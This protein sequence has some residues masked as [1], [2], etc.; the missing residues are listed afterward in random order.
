MLAGTPPFPGQ[1][2]D[3]VLHQHLRAAP[4]VLAEVPA[5]VAAATQRAMS[6]APA[7]RYATAQEFAAALVPPRTVAPS[8]PV[9]RWI[10]VGAV[11]AVAAVPAALVLS[12]RP[13]SPVPAVASVVGVLPLTPTV[14]DTHLARLGRDLV[15]TLSSN[16]DGVSG[17]RTV[18]ALTI[19]ALTPSS[20]S[21]TGDAGMRL[22][23][24]LGASAAVLGSIGREGPFL[25]VDARMVAIESGRVLARATAVAGLDDLGALTD[26]VTWTLLRGIWQTRAPPTPNPTALT[27]RSMPALRAFL[28]GE[29]E[30]LESRWDAASQSYE[31]AMQADSTFWLAYWRYAFARWWYLEAVDDDIIAAIRRHRYAL[32]ERDRLVFDSWVTDTF[33]VAVA[34]STE[35]TRRFPD[36]WPGWMQ[37]ADWLFHV[38][39]VYGHDREESKAALRRTVAL[40]PALIPAWEHL[41]WA[42]MPDDPATA[43]RALEE[44]TRLGFSR[45]SAAEFGYDVGRVY[46]FQLAMRRTGLVDA[47]LRDSIVVELLTTARGRLG[48]GATWPPAQ[49]VLSER[50]LLGRPRL[51]MAAIH[52]TALA[53]AWASRGAWDSAVTM[54]VRHSNG[55]TGRDPLFGYRM[56]V[57]GAWLGAVDASAAM[58]LRGRAAL[59][60]EGPRATPM[61]RAELAWLDGLAAYAAREPRALAGARARLQATDTVSTELLD[62]TLGA[63]EAELAGQRDLAARTL[64]NSN[65][66]NPDLL[67]PGYA[68]HPFVISVSRLAAARWLEDEGALTQADRLLM[69]FE[70]PFALDGY[71]PA[72]RVLGALAMLERARIAARQGRLADSRRAYAEFLQRYDAPVAAHAPLVTEARA[73]A[74]GPTN[75]EAQNGRRPRD[76]RPSP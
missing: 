26:S 62:K 21:L 51:A 74:S 33:S 27:T 40:N 28:Q 44:L 72:R 31:R 70:A 56:A 67:V 11:V 60:A 22:V 16:L 64:A 42:A 54:A 19:L 18:D 39:P 14:P 35:V 52:E 43:G 46:R 15:V 10:A 13:R 69:W 4:P 61:T 63:F 41:Y 37:H 38:G 36:Y 7:N 55:Q 71:R 73:Q 6:K 25:R 48:G 17:L 53:E 65:W 12:G 9:R 8:G 24:P 49:A 57:V 32:P 45:T 23:S 59:A 2:V 29:R 68:A 34:H 3:D 1:S 20:G 66:R 47:R 50:L 5:W 58:G 75:E 30:A 76:N